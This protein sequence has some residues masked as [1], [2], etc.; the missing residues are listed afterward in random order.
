MV[1]RAVSDVVPN[2]DPQLREDL[3]RF[4]AGIG[5]IERE[6]TRAGGHYLQAA[7][8]MHDAAGRVI[9]LT[10]ALIDITARRH[11]EQALE[12]ASRHW[13][14]HASHD[15][16][17]GLPNRRHIDQ[18][19]SA[20][21][22]RCARSA[23]PLSVL[24]IDVD[25]FKKYNDHVGH[26][27]GDECLRAIARQ[28]QGMV[29]REGDLVG[30]Y[31]GEE[32]IALL[33]GSD[34]SSAH[35]VAKNMLQAIKRLDIKHPASPYGCVT[36]SIGVASMDTLSMH[37][38]GRVDELLGYADR[39]LYSAKSAGRNAVCTYPPHSA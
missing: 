6:V 8:P 38:Q 26:Q 33:P 3:M 20:E 2:A 23:V 28:L 11:M 21:S 4:D 34:I 25:F 22:R 7:R 36:L 16:L 10:V 13:Q 14:F 9:G 35:G 30:R 32:F 24:M 5:M 31:G 39:A 15:H 18:A 1:G 17:T 19:I 29:R 27:R 37:M 12:K